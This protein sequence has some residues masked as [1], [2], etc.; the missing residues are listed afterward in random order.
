MFL[1]Q[2]AFSPKDLGTTRVG[3]LQQMGAVCVCVCHRE[4][5]FVHECVCVSV[6][7]REVCVC[8]G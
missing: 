2:E 4:V 8:E 6:C 5:R 1:P 7:Q 3:F